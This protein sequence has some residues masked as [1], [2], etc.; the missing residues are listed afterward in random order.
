[1]KKAY[2]NQL[3]YLSKSFKNTALIVLLCF[4][5]TA[6]TKKQIVTP[7][8]PAK[9]DPAVI[10]PITYPEMYKVGYPT[11]IAIGEYASV[12]SLGGPVINQKAFYAAYPNR[13]L[14][15]VLSTQGT[16][17]IAGE[18]ALNF[19]RS[20]SGKLKVSSGLGLFKSSISYFDSLSFRSDYIY[21]SYNLLIRQKRIRLNATADLLKQYLT[22]EF[23]ADVLSQSPSDIVAHYGTHIITDLVTGGKFV[24]LYRARTSSTDRKSAASAGLSVAIKKLF[25]LDISGGTNSSLSATNTDQ[26]LYYYAVGGYSSIPLVGEVALGS[27]VPNTI[28]IGNW[29]KSVTADNS[30][31]I[32]FGSSDSLMPIYDLIPDAAKATAVKAYVT[33]Y[34]MDNQVKMV[35]APPLVVQ[36]YDAANTNWAYSLQDVPSVY[37]RLIRQGPVFRAYASKV[38]GSIGIYQYYCPANGDFIYSKV[39][40]ASLAGYTNMGIV[41][42]AFDKQVAGTTPVF[43]FLYNAKIHK[44]IYY[45]HHYSTTNQ[46]PGTQDWAYTG[47]VFYAY[48]L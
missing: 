6:C 16:D 32:D 23:K 14:F 20:L 17:V 36:Y 24:A 43:E 39:P 3:S 28:Q 2:Q 34:L 22:T 21:S 46:L 35:D 40:D 9:P 7:T 12:S 4:A 11:N 42:Y 18:N 13:V 29:Q 45:G 10:T 19:S 38:D 8:D 44:H 30:V 48:S 33:Q 26:L 5:I 25:D 37:G 15:D 27:T 41:F 31:L 1:M 47:L